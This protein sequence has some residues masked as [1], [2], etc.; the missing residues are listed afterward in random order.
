MSK[1]HYE[2]IVDLTTLKPTKS[3]SEP[4]QIAFYMFGDDNSTTLHFDT[5]NRLVK[6]ELLTIRSNESLINLELTRITRY[7]AELSDDNELI[8]MDMTMP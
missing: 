6:D 1:Y 8:E 2:I 3:I 7:Q 5:N 4:E